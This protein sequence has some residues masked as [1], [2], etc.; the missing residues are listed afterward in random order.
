MSSS[1]G[2]LFFYSKLPFFC[3]KSSGQ[4]GKCPDAPTVI[5]TYRQISQVFQK[6]AHVSSDD[7][8]I[9][10]GQKKKEKEN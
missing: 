6:Q 10:L 9:N 2:L 4:I 1:Y 7:W 8:I 5:S 3:L